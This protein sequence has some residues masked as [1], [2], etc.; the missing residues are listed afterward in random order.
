MRKAEIIDLLCQK[1]EGTS[2]FPVSPGSVS[3]EKAEEVKKEVPKAAAHPAAQTQSQPETVS[4][5]GQMNGDQQMMSAA[6]S[7]RKTVVRSYRQEGQ[8]RPASY[9]PA[10]GNNTESYSRNEARTESAPEEPKAD[11]QPS[12]ELQELDSGIEAHAARLL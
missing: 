7:Q 11:F 1:E 6:G 9:R 3:A 5:Q 12:P 8:Q 4:Q 2:A 10:P